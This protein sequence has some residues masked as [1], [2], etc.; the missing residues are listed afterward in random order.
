LPPGPG[1]RVHSGTKRRKYLEENAEAARIEPTES[2]RDRIEE[3]APK[4]AAAGDRY[5]DIGTINL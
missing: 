4:D 5:V 2:D 3:T 1:Y